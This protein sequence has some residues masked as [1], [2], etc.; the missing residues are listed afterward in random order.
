M[1]SLPAICAALDEESAAGHK[2]LVLIANGFGMLPD[3]GFP[4]QV[5]DGF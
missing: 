2:R 5:G 3:A 4:Q 1:V